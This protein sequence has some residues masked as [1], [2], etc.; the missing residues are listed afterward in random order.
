MESCASGMRAREETAPSHATRLLHS[1]SASA[2]LGSVCQWRFPPPQ[3]RVQNSYGTDASGFPSATPGLPCGP[4]RA[5]AHPVKGARGEG[6]SLTCRSTASQGGRETRE[7]AGALALA[8]S[9]GAAQLPSPGRP[10]PRGGG[11]GAPPGR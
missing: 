10:C 5:A 11:H 9:S 8:A 6:A 4:A 7:R 3:M 1:P 2:H